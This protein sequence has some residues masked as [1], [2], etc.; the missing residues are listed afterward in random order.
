MP[1]CATNRPA[2]CRASAAPGS[3]YCAACS[4]RVAEQAAHYAAVVAAQP[5]STAASP[6]GP[7][8]G[9]G[10]YDCTR[11]HPCG[12]CDVCAFLAGRNR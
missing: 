4:V 10:R 2:R 3:I 6:H 12:D 8:R 11:A 5:A 7:A 1:R 9:G